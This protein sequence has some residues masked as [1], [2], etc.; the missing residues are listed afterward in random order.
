MLAGFFL[1]PQ[2][3]RVAAPTDGELNWTGH[4]LTAQGVEERASVH[5]ARAGKA[6]DAA[7]RA[8]GVRRAATA[9]CN[10]GR[11]VPAWREA[12][13][14]SR[15]SENEYARPTHRLVPIEPL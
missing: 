3:R 4:R 11:R 5:G 10:G 2:R 6:S 8:W 13:Q 14:S 7:L 9:K 12:R 1:A 15:V